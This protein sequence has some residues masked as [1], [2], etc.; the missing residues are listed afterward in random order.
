MTDPLA[1]IQASLRRLARRERVLLVVK[2]TCA[3]TV[4]L[5]GG[6]LG[7]VLLLNYGVR[8][9][10]WG[11]GMLGLA[12]VAL[13]GWQL[14]GVRAAAQLRRQAARVEA[15]APA[16]EGELLTVLDR[17]ARPLGS[18]VLVQRMAN[19]VADPL[20]ALA[21]ARVVPAGPATRWAL[22]A[23]C[24]FV[25]LALSNLLAIGPAAVLSAFRA[26]GAAVKEPAIEEGPRALVGDIT[27]RYLYPTYTGLSPMEI[28]N[29][30]GD[31]HA[32]PG[33]VV[34]IRARAERGWDT[35]ELDAYGARAPAQIDAD[36]ALRSS[37]SV[38]VPAETEPA[39]WR[40]YFT[41]SAG[42]MYS[43]D[44]RIVVDPDLAP[45]VTL[46]V[47][48]ARIRAAL[49]QPLGVA[50]HVHDDYGV[51]TVV[52]EIREGSST[53][54]V[55]VRA[56]LNVP[57]DVEDTLLLTPKQLGLSP[58]SS[59]QLRLKAW[60]ND[61]V[62]GSKAGWS[63]PVQLVVQGAQGDPSK[64]MPARRELR[65][66]LVLVLADFLL[67][68]SPPIASPADGEKWAV[69]ANARYERVDNLLAAKWADGQGGL[70]DGSALRELDAKRR[71]FLA[72]VRGLP[73]GGR[74]AAADRDA[75]AE[76]QAAHVE[77]LEGSI[78][79]FDTMIQRAAMQLVSQVAEDMAAEA[80]EMRADFPKVDKE[81]AAQA[82]ARL[83]QLARMLKA[84]SEAAA[85]VGEGAL[86]E[87]TNQGVAQLSDMLA[88]ARKAIEEGRYDDAKAMMDRLAE[89][90]RQLA[91]GLKDQQKRQADSSN[92]VANAMKDL[93]TEMA[94]LQEMQQAVRERTESARE[95]HGASM[96]EALAVWKE[97]EERAQSA[98]RGA[99]AVVTASGPLG[100]GVFRSA[101]DMRA[102]V[103][104]L[105]DAARARN[106]ERTRSR[107]EGTIQEVQGMAGTLKWVGRDPARVAG[108]V[109]VEAA[110]P[111]IQA[112]AKR[113]V[114]LLDKLQRQQASPELQR[115][116]EQLADQQ[117][118]INERAEKVSK[119]AQGV[120]RNLPMKAPGLQKGA[121][122]AAEESG[123]ATQAMRDG[124]PMAATGG[125]QATEDGLQEA[126]DA[127]K[128]AEQTMQSMSKGA[129]E[130]GSSGDGEPG[131]EQSG[132]GQG[133]PM[134]EM[135]LPAPE[136]F[137][138]PEAYRQAL[139]E[140]MQG[141]VPE[142]YKSSNLRYYEELVRQ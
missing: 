90:M 64:M 108:A 18:P 131:D 91:D 4:V 68:A 93:D 129:G 82:L 35:V 88:E 12:S 101:S 134:G 78:L 10:V 59:V 20:D 37:L 137:Q 100:G 46:D 84:L 94:K 27:L 139:M 81:N 127:L 44:Y 119:D 2:A 80:E 136:Q 24:A 45:Q 83:D 63:A 124:D 117:Q 56:P 75:I 11:A 74:L 26:V 23:V 97:I 49:D 130:G 60:D 51:K 135:T 92:A 34:E 66:A 58:G 141:D 55:E 32:P 25:L 105:L 40:F 3:S 72:T 123:R 133:S 62:S 6:W 103:E 53:R 89:G 109:G 42:S 65:D 121:E 1:R 69:L 107:A 14:R 30:N 48:S 31:V 140:G 122:Q 47:A 86:A 61:D 85:Q 70:A 138:T 73:A 104:G 16:F 77:A 39:T 41:G 57:R 28:P 52:V 38:R 21:P 120:A 102:E 8:P 22:A 106:V 96:D 126:R 98:S 36:R 125:Q 95:E 132:S 13:G 17:T 9:S 50:W 116:L 118:E 7:G 15:V 43:P 76:A 29:S 114:A 128:Q 99:G 54:E 115:A 67:D 87:F 111:P 79:L 110:L 19:R 142:Q 113:I 112:D 71:A 33:T 5:L